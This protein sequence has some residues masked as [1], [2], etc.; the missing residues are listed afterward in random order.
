MVRLAVHSLIT[1]A[2]A[3][4]FATA[5]WAQQSQS[6][7]AGTV[8]DASG[9]AIAGAR[10]EAASD[11]LIEKVRTTTTD[12]QGAYRIVALPLGNY[13]VTFSAPGF[14]TVKTINLDLPA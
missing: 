4:L 1:A 9:K 10:V 11:A 8:R 3:V 12:S 2:C 7:I 13:T 5:A 14:S 6:E